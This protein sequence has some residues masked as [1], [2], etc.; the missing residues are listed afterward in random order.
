MS[1]SD[2][3]WDVRRDCQLFETESSDA[4]AG[5]LETK[6]DGKDCIEARAVLLRVQSAAKV[7]RLYLEGVYEFNSGSAELREQP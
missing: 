6:D 4:L 2:T 1:D 5:I 3:L 7:L